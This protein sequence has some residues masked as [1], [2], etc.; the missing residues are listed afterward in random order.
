LTDGSA[1]LRVATELAIP[2]A[3]GSEGDA[4]A[5][6]WLEER[7]AERGLEPETQRFSYDLR[8]AEHALRVMLVAKAIVLASAVAMGNFS[9][10]AALLLLAAAVLPAL[11]FLGWSPWLERLYFRDG[12]TSTANV[13]ARRRAAEARATLVLMAH[14]DSKSQNLS[15][16]TRV[17]LTTV[18]IAGAAALLVLLVRAVVA[19]TQPALLQTAIAGGAA[20]LAVL[21]L[22]T[23]KSGNLSP[24]GVD[25]AGSVAIIL[26]AATE[27]LPR[28]PNDVELVVLS[29]GAEEDHMVGAMR[30]LEAYAAD[31]PHPLY[32]LNAD[33][34]GAPGRPVLIERYGLGRHFSPEMAAAARRAAA[35]LGLRPRGILMLPGVGIDTI[36]FAHRGIAS[37]TFASGS[38]GHATMSVHSAYDHAKH[39]DAGTLAI[40]TD[41][42]VE[43]AM[44]LVNRK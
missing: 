13:F 27:L 30:W 7:L 41:L 31:L 34:A 26:A 25:N 12:P 20:A 16:P 39:L 28:L 42:M 4:R 19:D 35:R 14:H 37:L 8:P 36:P 44:E 17:G 23:L 43:T 6:R 18:A 9:P 29:P 11:V 40:M 33:G 2:R 21:V 22:A 3:A 15:M 38:L 1:I 10:V 24:G 32:C 5:I